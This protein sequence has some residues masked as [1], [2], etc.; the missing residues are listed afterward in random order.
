MLILILFN[1]GDSMDNVQLGG[2]SNGAPFSTRDRNNDES[3]HSCARDF[4]SGWWFVSCSRA[5]LNGNYTEY[6]PGVLQRWYNN[7]QNLVIRRSEMMIT[8][9]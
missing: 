9:Y 1:I 7:L 2:Q 6:V 5:D 4:H 8:K 3:D